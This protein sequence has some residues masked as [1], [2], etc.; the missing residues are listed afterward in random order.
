MQFFLLL[1][2]SFRFINPCESSEL[3]LDLRHEKIMQIL[4]P[5]DETYFIPPQ[6]LAYIEA[7]ESLQSNRGQALLQLAQDYTTAIED[8]SDARLAMLN[9]RQ[10]LKSEFCVRFYFGGEA[11]KKNAKIHSLLFNHYE[12]ARLG[13]R[14]NSHLAKALPYLP[15]EST[16]A[17]ECR[18]SEKTLRSASR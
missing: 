9:A 8:L 1:L 13:I 14:L 2:L 18:F 3:S 10:I 6:V 12:N 11:R 15:D 4:G 5:L 7:G 17:E 16:W